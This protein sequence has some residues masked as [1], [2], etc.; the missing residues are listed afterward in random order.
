M[1]LAQ[2]VSSIEGVDRERDEDIDVASL[3]L[4]KTLSHKLSY[5]VL[6]NHTHH[7]PEKLDAVG[8][9][10]V[11][12]TKRLIQVFV[13]CVTCFLAAGITF[14]FAALKS[15]LVEEKVYRDL[16]TEDELDRD[17]AICY[18]Q[19]QRLNLTFIV[20]SVTANMG[21]LIVGSVLDRYG[22]KVCG[23]ASSVFL[24]IGSLCMAFSKNL[25]F[26]AYVAASFFL[27][28]GGIFT[29]VPSFHLCNAFPKYQGLILALITGAFD[30]SAA[31]FLGFRLIYMSTNGNFELRGLFLAYL[32]VPVFIIVSQVFVM[33]DRSYET[34]TELNVKMELAEDP[35]TD[36]HDSDDELDNDA[37]IWK[38]RADR[39]IR[40]KQSLASIRSLLG[41]QQQ[42]EKYEKKEEEKKVAS[43]VW[44]ALHGMSA[45]KQIQT[46][47]FILITILTVLQMARFNF[48]IATIWT[49]YRYL[50][51]SRQLATQVNDFFDLALPLGGVLTVPFIGLLLDNVSTVVVL[52]LIVLL[53]TITGVLAALPALWAAYANIC[54]FVIFRPLY[55]SA[56]SDYAAKVFGFAT[57]GTV[58][59]TIICL[60]GLGIFCQSGLQALVH[61]V[62]Q[63]DPG[64][65]NLWLAGF[66]LVLGISLVMYVDMRGRAVMR[67]LAEEDERRSIRPRSRRASR[68]SLV[69]P[70]EERRQWGSI[71]AHPDER[72]PLLN[73]GLSTVQER[74]ESEGSDESR[75]S[76]AVIV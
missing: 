71:G 46:P 15:V 22:P 60:A 29:F 8:A 37:E 72:R 74:A 30:A 10:E 4:T 19:D 2:H 64:P 26:D 63:E 18:L 55:Y 31:V 70:L 16:C 58:Y 45:V 1:S 42:Q 23:F 76:S 51:Q 34:R 41:T 21:A 62:F 59:G 40:R 12:N 75:R 50:L 44:G 14:G 56:M 53:S 11:P 3:V 61:D 35:A 9:Y 66:G 27:A 69:G 28:L 24:V 32:V 52:A 39:S 17:T 25:P 38:I 73:R 20:A 68:S 43:G 36:L 7:V 57:F 54:L 13:G 49:Q 6:P 47:W 65:M 48:T 5:D 67:E 33:P